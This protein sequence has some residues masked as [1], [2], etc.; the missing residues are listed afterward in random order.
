MK[1][2]KRVALGAALAVVAL[3][4]AAPAG[5]ANATTYEFSFSYSG[6]L[7]DSG[8]C[9]AVSGSGDLFGTLVGA[10][11]YLLTS[12]FGTSTE[13]GTLTL[14]PE[15]TYINTLSPSVNLTS[16][17]LLFYSGN[18]VLDGDGLVFQ[19]SSLP[20]DSMYFNIWGDGPNSYTY[21][22]NY[23]G[24]FPALNGPISFSVDFIGATPLPSAWTMLVAGFLGFGLLA[25]CGSRKNASAAAVA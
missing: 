17:N 3:V 20:A 8:S 5:Q 19:G 24:P 2:L 12:G 23:S 18:P 4:G 6:C 25:Y 11:E 10:G 21:F 9:D 15:G 22:N 7:P 13:A 1:S 14:E 16:D